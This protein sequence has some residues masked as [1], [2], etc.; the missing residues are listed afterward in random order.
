MATHKF[1]EA[2][3]NKHFAGVKDLP[4]KQREELKALLDALAGGA[5][6]K[7]MSTWAK[8]KLAW[9]CGRDALRDARRT[10]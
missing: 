3:F 8:L 5:R 7:P 2:V 1:D 6:L 9:R 10:R 4:Q